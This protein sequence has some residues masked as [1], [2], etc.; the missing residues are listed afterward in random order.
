MT[1]TTDI[2]L[3]HAELDRTPDDQ[4]L[5]GA[6]ADAL[7]EIGSPLAAG[8]RRLAELDKYPYI[9][10]Y[11]N[12][13]DGL[14]D[15]INPVI[16]WGTVNNPNWQPRSRDNGWCR[17]FRMSILPHEW[18]F[19]IRGTRPVEQ[20]CSWAYFYTR[21]QAED[22]ASRAYAEYSSARGDLP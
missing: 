1:T 15:V 20:P 16:V 6:L 17:R 7:E 19:L 11:P 9:F 2:D 13:H 10:V 5:R 3:L 8:Y 4:V 14:D 12:T 22:E 18:F 21:R